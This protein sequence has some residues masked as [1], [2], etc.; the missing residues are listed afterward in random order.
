MAV[1]SVNEKIFEK[2]KQAYIE[3]FGASPK[4]LINE[5]NRVY[6]EKKEDSKDII[7]DKTIRNFFK[8]DEASKMQEK[9]LNFLCRILLEYESYQEALR[10]QVALEQGEPN[11]TNPGET[12][13]ER[14]QE[15]LK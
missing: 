15:Y 5:L 10:H 4:F 14:Y 13:L 6:Q 7:S 1:I 2:L 12:W 11:E 3:K 9:N 8:D